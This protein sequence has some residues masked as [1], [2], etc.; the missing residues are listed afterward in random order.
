MFH[1]KHF[2]KLSQFAENNNIILSSEDMDKFSLFCSTLIAENK[3]MNLTAIDDPK[4]I[5]I[6]HFIDS[7]EA[8]SVIDRLWKEMCI[9]PE[10]DATEAENGFRLVDIGT[11]AG[12]PGIPLKIY[13]KNSSFTLLDSL[14]KRILFLN[15]VIDQLNLANIE[16]V[17]ARAEDFAKVGSVSRETYDFCVSR[18]VADMAVLLEYCLPTL[19]VG[20]YC[21]LYKSGDIKDELE[22]AQKAIDILGGELAGTEE[23]ILPENGDGRS[24][25]IIKKIKATPEKYPRR[26]GKPSKQPLK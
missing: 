3:V 20:G 7:L 13:Y 14:N 4:E 23:F 17:S 1:V 21:I 19:K 26:S 25:V 9:S 2:E 10:L 11:G 6:K 8:V 22:R 18:A 5:E 15:K 12:F 16:T 24:L